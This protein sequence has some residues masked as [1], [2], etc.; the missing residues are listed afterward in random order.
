M[1]DSNPTTAMRSSSSCLWTPSV[2]WSLLLFI[3]PFTFTLFVNRSWKATKPNQTKTKQHKVKVISTDSCFF[4][5]LGHKVLEE[6]TLN[7][8]FLCLLLTYLPKPESRTSWWYKNNYETCPYSLKL[9]LHLKS[10]GPS[11]WVFLIPWPELS[12]HEIYSLGEV[13]NV[14]KFKYTC[15]VHS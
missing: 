11:I 5:Q 14:W 10:N 7:L 13:W 1:S 9:C 15:I 12:S 6:W 3:L 4:L 8:A 2:N